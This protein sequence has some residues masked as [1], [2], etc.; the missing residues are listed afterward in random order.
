MLDIEGSTFNYRKGGHVTVDRERRRLVYE[1][2][3]ENPY[4]LYARD[5]MC[6]VLKNR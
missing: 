1:C 3:F 5:L 2:Q 4:N 6:K